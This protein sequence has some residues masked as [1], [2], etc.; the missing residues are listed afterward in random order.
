MNES[1]AI[2]L[3]AELG[4]I[5]DLPSIPAV[6][7]EA[8][9]ILQSEDGDAE[10]LS[11][12]ISQDPV[13]TSR[14]LRVANSAVYAGGGG[15]LDSLHAATMRLGFKEVLNLCMTAG[16]IAAFSDRGDFDLDDF[17]DHSAT[18]ALA[19]GQLAV[20]AGSVSNSG[21]DRSG[22]GSPYYLAGLLHDVGVLA[23][24]SAQTE[25][26][27]EVLEKNAIAREPLYVTETNMLG[28]HH[29]EVGAALSRV[30]GLPE[31]VVAT[32]EWHHDPLAAPEEFQTAV[33]IVHLADW[34]THHLGIGDAG[35]GVID[36]FQD[37]AWID[38]GLDIT[39]FPILIDSLAEASVEARL[40]VKGKA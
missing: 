12:V 10:Q 23:Y 25:R 39:Q 13:L 37:Q 14:I 27:Q 7:L 3:L 32:A 8:V 19:S 1:K 30:W 17:W 40:V 11:A 26:Y 20:L 33:E 6:I 16:A 34:M 35:D 31:I 4:P 9:D 15:P 29:G 18:T 38:L 21:Q 36:R 5:E 24:R 28:F 2:D 22:V